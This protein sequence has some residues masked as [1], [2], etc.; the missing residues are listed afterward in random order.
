MTEEPTNILR[1]AQQNV[2]QLLNNVEEGELNEEDETTTERALRA[3]R[4]HHESAVEQ[5]RRSKTITQT[6]AATVAILES[7][8][9]HGGEQPATEPEGE[10]VKDDEPAVV[11]GVSD[12]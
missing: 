11:E 9:E 5:E 12:E 2:E 3:A 6:A 1:A 7:L 10:P 8:V 4:N